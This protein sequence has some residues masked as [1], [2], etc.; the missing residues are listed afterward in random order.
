MSMI[1][2]RRISLGPDEIVLFDD[3]MN[4]LC[5]MPYG[6]L[7]SLAAALDGDADKF[8]EAIDRYK[9]TFVR[10]DDGADEAQQ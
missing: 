8:Q 5:R 2:A 9:Q 1:G 7:L 3:I 10:A 4:L 6:S